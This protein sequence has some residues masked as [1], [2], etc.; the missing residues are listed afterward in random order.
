MSS[1]ANVR[2]ASSDINVINSDSQ[3]TYQLEL[4]YK[5]LLGKLIVAVKSLKFAFEILYLSSYQTFHVWV[6]IKSLIQ[7]LFVSL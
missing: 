6:Y 1:R 3:A 4:W 7:F 2:Q 5:L